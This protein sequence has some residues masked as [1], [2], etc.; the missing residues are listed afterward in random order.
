MPNDEKIIKLSDV[1]SILPAHPFRGS[2][3]EVADGTARAVQ[4]KDIEDDGAA[5]WHS[6]VRTELSG[7][8]EPNWLQPQDILFLVRGSRNIA[9]FLDSVPFPA[10]ISPHFLLLRVAPGA[11][12]LPA[13]VVWQ[14]NQL[15]AQ[16]YFEASAEGS[17]QRSIR[18]AVLADLPL[19]IPPQNTQQAVVR[20]AAAARQE[21]ETYKKLIANRKQEL[22]AV[23][24]AILNRKAP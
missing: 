12:V 2:I 23:A 14:M 9:V 10:V 11:G 13:F 1:V 19:V 21:A 15:P 18:K 16:R 20:L 3:E 8:R 24:S 5:R 22:R 7:R 17:V 6:L 4:M